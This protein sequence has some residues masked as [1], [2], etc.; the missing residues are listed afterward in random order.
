M[1]SPLPITF[2]R[3][4]VEHTPVLMTLKTW[5]SQKE[6]SYVSGMPDVPVYP[7]EETKIFIEI[8]YAHPLPYHFDYRTK[9]SREEECGVHIHTHITIPDYESDKAST[10]IYRLEKFIK[11][12]I[13]LMEHGY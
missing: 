7:N 9:I 10:L 11:D 13:K 8:F 12:E 3:P 1:S 4:V 6:E 2:K 5:G